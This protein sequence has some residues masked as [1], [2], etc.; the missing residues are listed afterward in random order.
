MSEYYTI[1]NAGAYSRKART[2]NLKRY[3]EDI[4]FLQ[5]REIYT[6][7]QLGNFLKAEYDKYNSLNT[8]LKQKAARM[9]ELK[10]LLRL[11][12]SYNELRSVVENIPPKGGFGRKREKYM[13]EH[14]VEIR[15]YYAAKRQLDNA[16]PDKKLTPKVWQAELDRLE[17]EY[18]AGSKTAKVLWNE[19]KHLR[20]I[21][22][23]VDIVLHDQQAKEKSQIEHERER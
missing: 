3:A 23:K 21:R 2:G 13:A 22:Y 18:A 16:L 14:D 11:T 7:D 20:D 10:T 9:K 15:R 8:S 12:E 1:R 19:L 5:G 17:Q 6:V 4:N